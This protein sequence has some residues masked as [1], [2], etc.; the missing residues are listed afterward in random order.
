MDENLKITKHSLK[1]KGNKKKKGKG[2][3][4]PHAIPTVD[5]AGFPFYNFP[6][7]S[8]RIQLGV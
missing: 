8:F 5:K 1:K 7:F 3:R 2:K 4:G 6:L